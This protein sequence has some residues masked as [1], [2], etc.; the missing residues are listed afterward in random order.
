MLISVPQEDAPN[1]IV[2]S[3]GKTLQ[4]YDPQIPKAFSL[5]KFIPLLKERMYASNP[6]TRMFLVSWLRLLDSIPDL[7]LV[8]YLPAFL[9]P[10][11][12]YL[13]SSNHDVKVVTA[14]FLG[15][16]LQEIKRIHEIKKYVS[17]EKKRLSIRKHELNDEL[18]S[19][20]N[21]DEK[22]MRE[23]TD[24]LN[25][26]NN[27]NNNN[28]IDDGHDNNEDIDR[29][30]EGINGK[31]VFSEMNHMP[32]ND[33]SHDYSDGGI[34]IPGQDTI[35]DYPKIIDI[36]IASLDSSEESIQLIL[37]FKVN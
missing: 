28:N 18:N 32:I 16:L 1:K 15:L 36:L 37:T 8:S 27:N 29:N 2:D 23:S 4:V 3:R 10:L 35:I 13:S 26:N 24:N 5:Q 25:D 20:A 22:D 34:Y 17:N 21:N 33:D 19:N 30:S 31:R 12:S 14:S 7:E 11:L 6:Y 9:Q